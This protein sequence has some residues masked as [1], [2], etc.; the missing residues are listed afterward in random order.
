MENLQIIVYN[1][2]T[3]YFELFDTN[4]INEQDK[5]INISLEDNVIFALLIDEV[6]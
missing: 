5:T 2:S 3:D 1:P 4:S 6:Y